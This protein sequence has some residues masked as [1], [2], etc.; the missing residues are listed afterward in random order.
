MD[1]RL[2][3]AW[4]FAL[5]LGLSPKARPSL[6]STGSLKLSLTVKITAILLTSICVV[7]E[8]C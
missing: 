7:S 1:G 5:P 3:L 4:Q 2:G 8:A 6:P